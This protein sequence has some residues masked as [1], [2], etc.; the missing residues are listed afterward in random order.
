MVKICVMKTPCHCGL[1]SFVAAYSG[2]RP[3]QSFKER[4]PSSTDVPLRKQVTSSPPGGL[5]TLSAIPDCEPDELQVRMHWPLIDL[6][7]K[8]ITHTALVKVIYII[9]NKQ[10]VSFRNLNCPAVKIFL[11]TFYI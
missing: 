7:L 8:N 2:L 10:K 11:R 6:S 1:F 4:S 5:S 3:T 9:V